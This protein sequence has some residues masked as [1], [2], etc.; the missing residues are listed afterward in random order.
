MGTLRCWSRGCT[1]EVTKL[2]ASWVSVMGAWE[3]VGESG[4]SGGVM[5]ETREREVSDCGGG[6]WSVGVSEVVVGRGQT[7]GVWCCVSV[8]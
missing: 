8:T 7:R 2:P 1:Y 4:G 5:G 3:V 6:G